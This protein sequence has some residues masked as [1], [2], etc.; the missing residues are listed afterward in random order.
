MVEA[1]TIATSLST[2]CPMSASVYKC[3]VL[4]IIYAGDS[5]RRGAGVAHGRLLGYGVVAESKGQD[6]DAED[7]AADSKTK[8]G[9]WERSRVSYKTVVKV[10][11]R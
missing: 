8:A 2:L 4:I 11:Q 1:T 10:L 5:Y 3:F 7:I 9:S 6:L